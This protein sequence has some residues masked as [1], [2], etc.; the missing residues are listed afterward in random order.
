MRKELV[1]L[2]CSIH[3]YQDSNSRRGGGGGDDVVGGHGGRGGGGGGQGGRGGDAQRV[4]CPLL[5]HRDDSQDW[6]S[7]TPGTLAVHSGDEEGKNR[8]LLTRFQRIQQ[9][10]VDRAHF[11][12]PITPSLE[13]PTTYF[14]SNSF[15]PLANIMKDCSQ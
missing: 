11:G 9:E 8:P 13:T 15:Q 3:D 4:S 7:F 1:A 6:G 10:K 14:L 2:F 12:L 5:L